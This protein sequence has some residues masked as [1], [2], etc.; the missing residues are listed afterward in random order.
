VTWDRGR[1]GLFFITHGKTKARRRTL[2]MSQR[3][4]Q[5]LESRWQQQGQPESGWAW[6]APTASGH[7]EASSLKKG[8]ARALRDSKV[9]HFVL[10][11]LRHTF[12]TA[13]GASGKV[14]VWR[15]AQI[16]GHSSIAMS[17]RY[18][19]PQGDPVLDAMALPSGHVFGHTP[20]IPLPPDV[21]ERPQLPEKTEDKWW[22][23][24]DSNL[25]PPACKFSTLPETA[26]HGRSVN[27]TEGQCSCA[28]ARCSLPCTSTRAT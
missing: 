23:V 13:L 10:Y 3:V 17:M 20:E 11:S 12:L 1:Y 28:F 24:Q 25:R 7:I 9:R 6:P 5:I 26:R 14:D 2:P 4:R 16:A 27:S 8:H 19:H 21:Q 15:L 18:V 22:A